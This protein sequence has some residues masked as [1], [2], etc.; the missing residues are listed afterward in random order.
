MPEWS[1]SCVDWADRIRS[2]RS[3]IPAPLFQEEAE[4]GLSVLRELKLVDVPGSPT[5]GECCAPWVF[6]LAASVFGAYDP[7]TGRRLITEWFVCVP[8]KN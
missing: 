1:T 7:E 4:R 2:G 3:I 6:E 8:K 5:I